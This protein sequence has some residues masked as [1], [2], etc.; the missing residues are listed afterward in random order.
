MAISISRRVKSSVAPILAARRLSGLQF[1]AH[2]P[3]VAASFSC[4]ERYSRP[5]SWAKKSQSSAT[6]ISCPIDV[7]RVNLAQVANTLYISSMFSRRHWKKIGMAKLLL[8]PRFEPK[9]FQ[10]GSSGVGYQ[11]VFLKSHPSRVQRQVFTS[12]PRQPA[13]IALPSQ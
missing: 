10:L 3:K 5:C 4:Q 6:N 12:G 8:A 1:K 11:S 13:R 9:A 7:F 2:L